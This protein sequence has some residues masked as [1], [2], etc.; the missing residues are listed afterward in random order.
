VLYVATELEA[1]AL[2][3]S[4]AG[5]D[6]G[7]ERQRVERRINHELRGFIDAYF[8]DV[9]VSVRIVEG[10]VAD[11]V[12]GVSREIERGLHRGGHARPWAA[13]PPDPRRHDP[14]HPAPCALP[15]VVVPL[16]LRRLSRQLPGWSHRARP[17]GPA[18]M[19]KTCALPRHR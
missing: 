10:D 2:G 11:Q 14:E 17:P 6:P 15:V 5:V 12:A 16:R 1:L 7:V 8:P 18:A 3:A 4:E 19:C 13:R 9:P